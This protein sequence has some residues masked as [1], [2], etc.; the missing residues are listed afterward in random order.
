[1]TE[2]NKLPIYLINAHGIRYLDIKNIQCLSKSR[3]NYDIESS[4]FRLNQNQY[5]I[6]ICPLGTDMIV[7]DGKERSN[8]HKFIKQLSPKDIFSKNKDDLFNIC[9]KSH[10]VICIVNEFN[11]ILNH[12]DL[13]NYKGG[14]CGPIKELYYQ[15]NPTKLY[16]D[17]DVIC[18]MVKLRLPTRETK[19]YNIARIKNLKQ[20]YK[21]LCIVHEKLNP[22]YKT[23][24][25]K[26]REFDM[27]HLNAS[28]GQRIQDKEFVFYD[29]EEEYV[30][31]TGVMEISD[32]TSSNVSKFIRKYGISTKDSYM[33]SNHTCKLN[34]IMNYTKTHHMQTRQY[35]IAGSGLISDVDREQKLCQEIYKSIKNKQ[36]VSLSK[37]CDILG[38]GIYVSLCCNPLH[39]WDSDS[40]AYISRTHLINIDRVK[41]KVDDKQVLENIFKRENRKINELNM[42]WKTTSF[43]TNNNI[44]IDV[45]ISAD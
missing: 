41:R 16:M 7:G 8:A 22:V 13:L 45:A 5:F 40:H 17:A 3:I 18:K 23:P 43:N 1:M 27:T 9:K 38:E 25:F 19:S 24:L 30:W 32:K 44:K 6:D 12:I 26:N 11:A 39:V 2:R 10:M 15:Y 21:K 42:G 28:P 33:N 29:D 31:F 20:A 35:D 37:I 4:Q 14:G 36:G 34:R